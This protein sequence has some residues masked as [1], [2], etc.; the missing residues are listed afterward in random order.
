MK[1]AWRVIASVLMVFLVQGCGGSDNTESESEDDST[2]DTFYFTDQYGLGLGV[3][4]ESNI[5][6]VSGFDVEIAVSIEGGEYSINGGEFTSEDGTIVDGQNVTVRVFTSNELYTSVS[7]TLTIGEVAD[8]FSGRTASLSLYARHSFKGLTFYWNSVSTATHYR[9]WGQLQRDAEY[10]QVGRDFDGTIHSTRVEIPLHRFDWF[11]AQFKL[12]ACIDDDCFFTQAIDVASLRAQAVGYIKADNT[13]AF[14]GLGVVAISADGNTLAV[15]AAG[16]D[17]TAQINGDRGSN[18]SS[19]SGAVYVY[20]K[21]G[22]D[23][24]FQAYLKANNVG[25]GD[26]FGTALSLSGDGNVLVVGAPYESSSA[27]GVGGNGGDN[28]AEHA[29]AAYVYQR[30]GDVWLQRSYLKASDTTAQALFGSSVAISAYGGTI[31]V[32]AP[33]HSNELGALYVY[34]VNG[35]S[36][37]V[38]AAL[39]APQGES[40]DR[41]GASISLSAAGDM[42]VVGAPGESSNSVGV[43][44]DQTDNNTPFAG[45]AYVYAR[46]GSNWVFDT[47]LKA[48]NTDRNQLLGAAVSISALGNTI[49]LGAPGESS[50]SVGLNGDQADFSAESSGAVYVFTRG[51]EMA[52]QQQAYVKASNTDIGDKFGDALALNATGTLLMVGAPNEDSGNTEVDS[53]DGDNAAVDAGAVYAFE[54]AEQWQQVKYVKSPNAGAGDR[55]GESLVIDAS[56]NTLVVGAEGEDSHH[57]GVDAVL[58]SNAAQDSGAVYLF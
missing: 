7:A 40:G 52:W 45:A 4:A 26:G 43:N 11:N 18:D 2:P 3:Y 1:N 57:V 51:N 37:Q 21:S 55:F 31:A 5:I 20:K 14:D 13:E 24:Y 17:S 42:L 50:S 33:K 30:L 16:E 49:A 29:G 19:G 41:Y 58:N 10:E 56:G 54:L 8:T 53:H 48:S 22:M 44:L 15:G 32:G 35:E 34:T 27:M 6:E 9:L 36:W 47:Y 25:A 39:R 12:E 46:Q 23:W 38:E 28:S